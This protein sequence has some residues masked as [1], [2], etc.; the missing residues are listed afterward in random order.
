MNARSCAVNV[1]HK[2]KIQYNSHLIWT[3]GMGR[4]GRIFLCM[5]LARDAM[6]G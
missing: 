4:Q 1:Y 6:G 3:V 5:D 2:E